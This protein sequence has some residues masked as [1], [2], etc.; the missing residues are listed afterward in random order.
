[1][2]VSVFL[3]SCISLV[4]ELMQLYLVLGASENV[5]VDAFVAKV[6]ELLYLLIHSLGAGVH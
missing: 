5:S 1:M 4:I 3:S 6:G 2:F